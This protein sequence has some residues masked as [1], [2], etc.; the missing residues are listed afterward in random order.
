M[1]EPTKPLMLR[2]NAKQIKK[3]KKRK[4]DI[5]SEKGE[6]YSLQKVIY[7]MIDELPGDSE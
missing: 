1:A 7:K 4:L 3:I 6:D 2:L 5:L